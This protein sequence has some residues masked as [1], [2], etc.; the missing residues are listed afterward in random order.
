MG[1]LNALDGEKHTQGMYLDRYT[2]HKIGNKEK[3]SARKGRRRARPERRRKQTISYITRARSRT[4]ELSVAIWNDL[5]LSLTGRRG[6][7]HAEVLLQKCQVLGCD[8]IGLQETRRPGRTELFRQATAYSVA[9]MAGAVVG[10][11]STGWG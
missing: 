7:G 10:L 9:R 4:G 5:S 1:P 11:D 6:A 2:K 3:K 8:V